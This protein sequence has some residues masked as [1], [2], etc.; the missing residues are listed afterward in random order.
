METNGFVFSTLLQERER[1][2]VE[3]EQEVFK[4]EQP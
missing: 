3:Q 1:E 2:R 4:W